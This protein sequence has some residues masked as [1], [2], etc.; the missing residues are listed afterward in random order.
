MPEYNAQ[1]PR[2][3]LLLKIMRCFLISSRPTGISRRPFCRRSATNKVR[4]F[5]YVSPSVALFRL[6]KIRESSGEFL[7]ALNALFLERARHHLLYNIMVWRFE[8]QRIMNRYSCLSCY[9]VCGLAT[10]AV[11]RVCKQCDMRHCC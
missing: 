4:L 2:Q 5:L 6:A 1:A 10:F 9:I 3:V 7:S 8:I 11:T